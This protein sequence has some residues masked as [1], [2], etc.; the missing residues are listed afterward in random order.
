M[1]DKEKAIKETIKKITQNILISKQS[2]VEDITKITHYHDENKKKI[3]D[4]QHDDKI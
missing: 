1:N 4:Y 2:I 3:M